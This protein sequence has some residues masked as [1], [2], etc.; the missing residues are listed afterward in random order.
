M[1]KTLVVMV[2]LL[3]GALLLSGC[4]GAEPA[5]RLE[6]VKEAG[7]I[8][9]GVSADYPPFSFVD[10]SGEFTGL[11][12]DVDREI[13]KRLGVTVEFVDVPFDTLFTGLQEGKYDIADGN[14][15]WTEERA[16]MMEIPQP[17]FIDKNVL[18]VH[19]DFDE[20]QIQT[21]EDIAKFKVAQQTGGVE[22]QFMRET[23][24]D[25][26]ILPADQLTL[27]ERVDSIAMDI[28]A[29]RQ[30][31][32]MNKLSV[33]AALVKELGDLKLIFID[34]LP[35][36]GVHMGIN[37]GETE[38]YEAVDKII[39]DLESEGFLTQLAAKYEI[40]E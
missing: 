32:T 25:P 26:G 19:S 34:G 7:V 3:A 8:K 6:A 13:A 16:E 5:N 21:V 38:L 24:V 1:K 17:Y 31:V 2:I 37:K 33:L 28:K 18:L 9:V 11:A 20:S 30:D 35:E 15:M 10:E 39:R 36:G 23:L 12:N 40:A 14:F 29:G 27:Y 22:E 4:G